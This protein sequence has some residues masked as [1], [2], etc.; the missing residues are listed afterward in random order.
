MKR[1]V[2]ALAFLTVALAVYVLYDPNDY[3]TLL[4]AK[5]VVVCGA[6]TGIGEQLA[7]VYSTY[8]A[9]LVITAR[10]ESMLQAVAAK[11]RQLG[12]ASIDYV[13]LDLAE[14]DSARIL[15]DFAQ[16]SMGGIDVVV[17]NH[18]I[19]YY[20]PW[21]AKS[22]AKLDFA[23][24]I[25][26]VNTW[27]YMSIATHALSALETSRGS[28]VVVSSFA[29]KVGAPFTEPYSASKHALHGFFDSLRHDLYFQKSNI[30]ITLCV[31]GNIDTETA[32]NRVGKVVTLEWLS[33][34]RT[35]EAIVKG[36]ARRER[37]IYYPVSLSFALYLHTF[38][39]RLVDAII[40]Q[41]H[42]PSQFDK[43]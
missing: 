16:S 1:K 39:P 27:S 13:P 18:I 2:L 34:N 19:G 7:Y 23:D 37:E 6:S 11:C 3:A 29:G 25:L 33:A 35:A 12:A 28:L 14:S 8:G 36:G 41:V 30:S 43:Q 5:R 26:R 4:A 21:N 22:I 38:F 32:M 15:V 42:D 10:R 17:L 9:R 20:A 24:K 31:L 40:H